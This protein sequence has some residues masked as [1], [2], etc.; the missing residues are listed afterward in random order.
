MVDGLGLCVKCE[1]LQKWSR[2]WAMLGTGSCDI[3]QRENAAKVAA[4]IGTL[5][6]GVLVDMD[7]FL[8]MFVTNFLADF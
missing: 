7:V 8:E 4:V 1:V 6:H 3:F 2:Q 5:E